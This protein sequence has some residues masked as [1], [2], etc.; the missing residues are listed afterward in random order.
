AVTRQTLNGHPPQGFVPQE[1]ISLE[2]AIK[3]YTLGAAIAGRREK[4]EGSLEPGKLADLIVVS[5]D[6]FK[7]KPNEIASEEVLLTI[8][9]GKVVY[10]SPTWA[11]I[12][13]RDKSASNTAASTPSA[14]A[15]R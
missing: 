8:V 12:T 3:G 14:E 5:Q 1:R 6:L 9:G 10:E 7:I 2:D 15:P 4:T 13:G 11:V